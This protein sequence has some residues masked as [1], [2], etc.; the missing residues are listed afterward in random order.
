MGL[1]VGSA[2]FVREDGHA[3]GDEK[4]ARVVPRGILATT[5]EDTHQHYGDHLAALPQRLHRV[6]HVV[7][8]GEGKKHGSQVEQSQLGILPHRHRVLGLSK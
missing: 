4:C 1:R 3:G 7:Q 8:G 2:A 5:D 6:R